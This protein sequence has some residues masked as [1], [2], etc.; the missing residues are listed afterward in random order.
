MKW[1][2]AIEKLVSGWQLT[3]GIIVGNNQMLR[4]LS[5]SELWYMFNSMIFFFQNWF[6]VVASTPAGICSDI[7]VVSVVDRKFETTVWTLTFYYTYQAM[8][9]QN[10]ELNFLQN[11]DLKKKVWCEWTD[12]ISVSQSNNICFRWDTQIASCAALKNKI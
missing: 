7:N 11:L 1:K 3:F 10:N 2:I 6:S 8:R 12:W 5:E 4:I 9:S